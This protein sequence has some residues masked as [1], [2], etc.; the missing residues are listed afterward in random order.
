M[1][2]AISNE[3]STNNHKFAIRFG[4][5]A[6]KAVGLKMMEVAVDERKKKW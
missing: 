3:T 2:K 1:N 4:L 5:G 6:I